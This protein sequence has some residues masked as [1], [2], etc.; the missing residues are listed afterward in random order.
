MK[1]KICAKTNSAC[2][3]FNFL[4]R[5][6]RRTLC[7]KWFTR[8]CIQRFNSLSS[9]YCLNFFR[10]LLRDLFP[11]HIQVDESFV[12]SDFGNNHI[13]GEYFSRAR[14]WCPLIDSWMDK[15]IILFTLV[16]WTWHFGRRNYT[17]LYCKLNIL[18]LKA[19]I[20]TWLMRN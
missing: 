8:G 10:Q 19:R 1:K 4:T 12:T 18:F 15:E 5:H 11:L 3:W 2:I 16:K 9:F 6:L 14:N 13:S 7:W 20:E 17:I